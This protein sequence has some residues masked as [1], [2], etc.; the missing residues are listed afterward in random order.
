MP[1]PFSSG[2]IQALQTIGLFRMRDKTAGDATSPL[3]IVEGRSILLDCSP[4]LIDF[5]RRRSRRH[6]R[7]S[8][9]L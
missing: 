5:T 8:M 4:S 6:N 3:L 1:P 2:G 9:L 7:L